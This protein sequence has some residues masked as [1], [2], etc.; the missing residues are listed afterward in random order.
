[1]SVTKR[2]APFL[3]NALIFL[4]IYIKQYNRT[5]QLR[6]YVRCKDISINIADQGGIDSNPDP[7]PEKKLD[8]KRPSGKSGCS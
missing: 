2:I 3:Y 8:P 6:V 4:R 7:T 5:V 1:M